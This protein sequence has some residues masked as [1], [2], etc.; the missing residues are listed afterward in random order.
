[1]TRSL[2]KL[3]KKP[4]DKKVSDKSPTKLSF[5][6]NDKILKFIE[7]SSGHVGKR[8][9]SRAFKLNTKQKTILK[10]VLRE[11]KISGVIKKNRGKKFCKSGEIP[12]V[13]VLQVIG[14]DADGDL[15]ARPDVWEGDDA[16]PKIYIISNKSHVNVPKLGERLLA[17]LAPTG[18]GT[19]EA[20]PIRSIAEAPKQVLG[21]FESIG[22]Q[23][24]VRPTDR[25][26]RGEFIIQT[27]DSLDAMPGDLV[28]AEPLPGRQLGLRHARIVERLEVENA[29]YAHSMIAIVEHDIP[30][31]FSKA[32]L[33]QAEKAIAAPVKGREDIR[34]IPLVTIDGPDARDFDDAVWAESDPD[35]K[36][37]GGWHLLVA[38]ADVAWYVRPGDAL[39]TNA[40]E[41]GNSVYFPDRVVPMLPE[42]LSN[43][44]CSLVPLE[45]RPCM[46]AHL[47][48]DADGRLLRYQFCRS[49]MRSHARLTYQQVQQARDGNSDEITKP[50][51]VSVINPLYGAYKS[52][53]KDRAKRG[54]LELEM[55]ERKVQLDNKGK[56]T[57]ITVSERLDSH[58]LIE[59]FMI[60][61]NVAAAKTMEKAG[62]PSLYRVHDEPSQ[63]KLTNL[64]EV[65]KNVNI[66]FEKG[67]VS[68]PKRFNRVLKLVEGSPHAEMINV[69][70]LRS[71]AK[72]E[73]SP[74]NLGH[75]G[76]ALH[77][78]SHFTSP[79][80]RYSDLLVHRALIEAGKLKELRTKEDQ[81]YLVKIGEHLSNTERRAA[82]A[83]R[84]S[85]DRFTTSFLVNSIGKNFQG[86]IN[87][88]TR[89]GL[90]ITL[91][92]TGADG[93]IPIRSL[94]DDYY[95][96]DEILHSLRGRRTG[97][98]YRLGE[99]VHI[100]LTEASTTTGGMIFNLIDL[101]KKTSYTSKQNKRRKHKTR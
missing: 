32:A 33:R 67:G 47:W 82:G 70:V 79:I 19:F 90:F 100:R 48:I 60:S 72:A 38:I 34:N 77:R 8:E 30:T 87:G 93:L 6:S 9:I 37:L 59:E 22:G 10:K 56:V 68:S 64:H 78:Y 65:L 44:W 98:E 24:R 61:A 80:R 50:L 86:R 73:Y 36:N 4:A 81:Q 35:K 41:R 89:F 1:M 52:L 43:G 57:D 58:K 54:V 83:E 66:S 15:M 5:P 96:H 26:S 16:P 101:E 75:F 12:S 39:D 84:D 53:L 62:I 91:L 23:G 2:K 49:I 17:R 46:A 55:P 40:Y 25:R 76:L 29:N 51:L 45:D 21:I 28:R 13:M 88:V 20:R 14:P 71:Q 63:E 11:M 27:Q 94:A 3:S 95:I 42:A 18:D 97:H 92:D 69:M 7:D 99:T 31:R 85:I 74:I